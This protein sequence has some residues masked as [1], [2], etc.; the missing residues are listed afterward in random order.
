VEDTPGISAPPRA[1][2]DSRATSPVHRASGWLTTCTD[3]P[4]LQPLLALWRRLSQDHVTKLAAMLAY[5]LI[6]SVIPILVLLLSLFG[7]LLNTRSAQERQAILQN[8]EARSTG[9]AQ[10]VPLALA[11]LTKHA[12][13]LAVISILTAVYFGSG[14]FKAISYCF[15]IIFRAPRRRPVPEQLMSFEMLLLFLVLTPMMFIIT[16]IPGFLSQRDVRQ[17]V[18]TL[19][20]ILAGCLAGSFNYRWPGVDWR[21]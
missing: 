10:F 13:P 20:S 14:L 12:G 11:D 4:F 21:A 5:H 8:V 15:D 16:A 9:A 6:M 2:G 18:F 7:L 17:A 3:R 19:L 1:S